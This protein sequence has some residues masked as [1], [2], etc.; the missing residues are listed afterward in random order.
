MSVEAFI[1]EVTRAEVE[2]A[3]HRN[4]VVAPTLSTVPEGEIRV[5]NA[6]TIIGADLPEVQDYRAQG[7]TYE[8]H[9]LEARDVRLLIDQEKVVAQL[10][11]D[12]DARQAAGSLTQFTDLQG[13][14]LA[15]DTERYLISTMVAG[16]TQG[17]TTAVTTAAQAKTAVRSLASAMDE[18]EVPDEGRYLLVNPKAK[19][20]LV[21]AIGDSTAVQAGGTELRKNVIG[22]FAG[23][24]VIWTANVPASLRDSAAFVAYH[25]AAVAFA[26]QIEKSEAKRPSGTFKDELASLVVYGAKVTNPAGVHIA[27]F[28]KP[29]D[30]DPGAGDGT[31]D[32]TDG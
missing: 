20:L 14:A 1:P 19:A 28:T 7:R 15:R 12:I 27:G 25:S 4:A 10:V 9:E 16:A 6:V 32:G 26:P 8:A 3:Y 5:G 24:T 2:V 23:F 30:V 13:A 21:E 29:T 22:E 31:G 18:A 11:D 17:S